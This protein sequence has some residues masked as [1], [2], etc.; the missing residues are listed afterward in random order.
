MAEHPTL[1]SIPGGRE[2]RSPAPQPREPLWREVLGQRLRELR[3]DQDETLAETAGRAG[4][5]PQYLSEVERGRKEPSSEMI[6]AL[7]G[8]LGTTLAETAGRAGV[9]PQYLSEVERGRKEPSSEMIAALAGALGT[10]LAEHGPHFYAPVPST[11]GR[12][13]PSR[14]FSAPIPLMRVAFLELSVCLAPH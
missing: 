10:P 1:H 3:R 2:D 14:A 7:A 9:S 12:R 5:S 8:A 11:P 13:S 6:A 4:V